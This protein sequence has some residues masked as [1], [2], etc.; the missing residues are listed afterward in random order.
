MD[1]FQAVEPHRM[2]PSGHKDSVHAL[3][4]VDPCMGP[5]PCAL[6]NSHSPGCAVT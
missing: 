6:V 4:I 3:Y 5:V 1:L 2:K